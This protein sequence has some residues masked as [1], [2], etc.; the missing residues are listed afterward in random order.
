MDVGDGTNELHVIDGINHYRPNGIE[1]FAV[2]GYYPLYTTETAANINNL[3]T[4]RTEIGNYVYYMPNDS[5]QEQGTS[6]GPVS[7]EIQGYYPLWE[8]Q[9]HAN[10]EGNGSSTE[11]TLSGVT[12]YM[13][14]GVEPFAL[15]GYY[16]LYLTNTTA[17][18]ASNTSATTFEIDGTSFYMPDGIEP[19]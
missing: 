9:S 4:I 7:I 19:V 15:A 10:L 3:G 1:P 6:T 18:E 14:N 13:P 11:Y 16:P 2:A 17:I 12:Y 5:V 8:H